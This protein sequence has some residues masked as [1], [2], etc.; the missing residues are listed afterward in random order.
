MNHMTEH[1]HQQ[2][3]KPQTGHHMP[4]THAS[5]D[6]QAGHSVAKTHIRH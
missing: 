6:R 2:M 1:D 5:H 3:S 4:D